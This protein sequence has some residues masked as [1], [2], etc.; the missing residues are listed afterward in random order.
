MRS[1]GE[2]IAINE[3]ASTRA[4]LPTITLDDT[5]VAESLAAHIAEELETYGKPSS[6]GNEFWGEF[7]K[8]EHPTVFGV[9][10]LGRRYANLK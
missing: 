8:T 2:I 4:D 10:E 6:I 3:A 9:L 1:L 7:L 5:I